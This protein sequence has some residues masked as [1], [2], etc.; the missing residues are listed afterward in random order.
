MNLSANIIASAVGRGASETPGGGLLWSVNGTTAAVGIPDDLATEPAYRAI[1][2]AVDAVSS[3]AEGAA[4]VHA[5]PRLSVAAKA[6]D[7]AR[8]AAMARETI[9]GVIIATAEE[10]AAADRAAQA[11]TGARPIDPKDALAATLDAERRAILRAMEPAE[12]MRHVQRDRQCA[13]AVLRQ[14]I[15]IAEPVLEVARR[16]VL[17]A[18]PMA[19]PL[20]RRAEDWRKAAECVS[21]CRV[22]VERLSAGRGGPVAAAA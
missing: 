19:Y 21:Q 9:M 16:A 12:A 5:D 3:F 6:Q 17:A 4:R 20:R 13:D 1:A 18:D 15:G 11:E 7:V 14:P 8:L 2:R 22:A 10:V